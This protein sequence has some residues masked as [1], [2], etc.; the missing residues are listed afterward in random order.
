MLSGP[1]SKSGQKLDLTPA[2]VVDWLASD[3]SSILI[4]RTY[5]SKTVGGLISDTGKGLAV[6]KVNIDTGDASGILG[7]NP[8]VES[9]MSDGHGNIRLRK[10]WN[11]EGRTYRTEKVSRFSY[12]PLGGSEW[13]PLSTFN[14]NDQFGF[15]PGTVDKE[16]NRVLG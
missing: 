16:A 15:Y 6:D 1:R 14:Q 11:L 10:I 9:Y 13:R 4:S 5:A 8:T 2:E 12:L 3:P 7:P